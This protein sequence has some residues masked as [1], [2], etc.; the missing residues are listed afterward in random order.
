MRGAK[1]NKILSSLG[2]R[3]RCVGEAR[4][5]RILASR[6]R[7]TSVDEAISGGWFVRP[8]FLVS[9]IPSH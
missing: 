2:H 7:D 6:I 5:R 3:A 1:E 9:K 4:V 8:S